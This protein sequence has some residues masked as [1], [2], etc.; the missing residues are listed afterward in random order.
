MRLTDSGRKQKKAAADAKAEKEKVAREGVA[1]GSRRGGHGSASQGP[2]LCGTDFGVSTQHVARHSPRTRNMPCDCFNVSIADWYDTRHIGC[3]HVWGWPNMAAGAAC[4]KRVKKAKTVSLCDCIVCTPSSLQSCP[5]S[6][7]VSSY[8]LCLRFSRLERRP[9][10]RWLPRRR[11]QSW[12]KAPLPLTRSVLHQELSQGRLP[13]GTQLGVNIV[14]I[15][16]IRIEVVVLLEILR[17]FEFTIDPVLFVGPISSLC[18]DLSLGAKAW[19]TG[20]LLE[21]DCTNASKRLQ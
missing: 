7:P 9:C 6:S 8:A 21:L 18:R 1:Q 13:T 19:C 4:T 15:V 11:V 14:E 20:V 17:V 3:L 10:R 2:H 16:W 12:V 5:H